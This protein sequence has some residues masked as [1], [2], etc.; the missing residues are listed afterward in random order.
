MWKEQI[1]QSLERYGQALGSGDFSLV[2]NG[3]V[4]PAMVLS[5]QGALVIT[6]IAEVERFFAGAAEW[7][8]SQGVVS[9]VPEIVHSDVLSER[10]VAVD[11]RWPS[12]DADGNTVMS[13]LSHY[14]LEAGTDGQFRIRVALTR[15]AAPKGH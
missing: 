9:T 1:Q 7:Y 10:L 3:W 12:L 11:V 6:D 15:G 2:A 8:R 4:M 13:E 14:I 5:D